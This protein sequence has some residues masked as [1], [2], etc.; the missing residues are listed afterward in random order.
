MMIA[1]HQ[2]PAGDRVIGVGGQQQQAGG[3]EQLVGDRVEHAAD[4]AEVLLPGAGE[5]AVEI[6]GDSGDDEDQPK[7]SSVRSRWIAAGLRG[8]SRARPSAQRVCARR[9]ACSGG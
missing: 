1:A 7:R 2:R 4:V 5:V 3:D 8:R 6:V 9:S